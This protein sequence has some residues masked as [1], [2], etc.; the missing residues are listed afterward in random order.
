MSSKQEY[1][2]FGHFVA[3]GAQGCAADV[4]FLMDRLATCDDIAT[5]RLVDYALSLV[6][7]GE[8]VDR[9]QHFL[10][11]GTQRQRN[12]AALY[13]KRLDEY[14]ILAEALAQGKVDS[15]Q[16]YGR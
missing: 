8:G 9:L 1:G 4:D 15:L 5:T 6:E 14:G 11:N 16:V 13:F 7:T 12:Y 3:L 2:R 10:F